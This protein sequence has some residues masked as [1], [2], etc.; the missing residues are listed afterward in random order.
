MV[1]GKKFAEI[2]EPIC[3]KI[4]KYVLRF[5]QIV[6]SQSPTNHPIC[7]TLI[8]QLF[9][10]KKKIYSVASVYSG[11]MYGRRK[12]LLK[13]YWDHFRS[14]KKSL[15]IFLFRMALLYIKHMNS[16]RFQ[17]CPLWNINPTRSC[18]RSDNICWVL[19]IWRR[20]STRT[21]YCIHVGRKWNVVKWKVQ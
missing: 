8:L 11:F 18:T 5:Q 3:W 21:H 13:Q 15:Q 10:T 14:K 19:L 6:P 17:M 2:S 9:W 4:S 16:W 20:L 12:H 1:Y 7:F